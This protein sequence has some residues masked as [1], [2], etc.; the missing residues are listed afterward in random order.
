MSGKKACKTCSYR[1]KE[2]VATYCPSYIY[3]NK[4]GFWRNEKDP[5]NE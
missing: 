1:D 5:C 3:C 4:K 2:K